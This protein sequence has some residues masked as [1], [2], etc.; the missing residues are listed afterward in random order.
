MGEGGV[1]DVVNVTSVEPMV[2]FRLRTILVAT[3][4][5][6]VLAGLAGLY[7]R[8]QEPTAQQA[9]LVYWGLVTTATLAAFV[10]RW[11]RAMT[12]APSMG[13]VYWR[14]T[15][16]WR[17]WWAAPVLRFGIVSFFLLGLVYESGVIVEITAKMRPGTLDFWTVVLLRSVI[18]GTVLGMGMII[19]FIDPAF[20]CERGVWMLHR[21]ILWNRLKEWEWTANRPGVL[22]L[23]EAHGKAFLSVPA[24]RRAAVEAF[25]REKT[26][27]TIPDPQARVAVVDEAEDGEGEAV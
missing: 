22:R 1:T 15:S 21:T 12:P 7:F 16:A 5:A 11:R 3:T 24:E 25:I 19:N 20:V 4:V 27:L 18:W 2:R 10:W 17:Y 6:A 9:L 8:R 23:R 14:V 13:Q 26:E